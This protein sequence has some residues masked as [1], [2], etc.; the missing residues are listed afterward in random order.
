MTEIMPFPENN[1]KTVLLDRPERSGIF[2][3]LLTEHAQQEACFAVSLL[4]LFLKSA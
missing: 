4:R 2:L 1:C 3:Y